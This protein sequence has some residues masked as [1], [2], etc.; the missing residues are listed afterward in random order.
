MSVRRN[1]EKQEA[2]VAA[3]H[4]LIRD[5][6]AARTAGTTFTSGTQERGPCTVG[7]EAILTALGRIMETFGYVVTPIQ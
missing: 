1:V 4:E 2:V 3:L 7:R 5:N 6:D